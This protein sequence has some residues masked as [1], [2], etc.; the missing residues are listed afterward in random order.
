VSL[1]FGLFAGWSP[2]VALVLAG[3]L[4]RTTVERIYQA[5]KVR[6]DRWYFDDLPVG[7]GEWLE[8]QARDRGLSLRVFAAGSND[9]DIDAYYPSAR[10]ILLSQEVYYKCD[11]SFWAVAA[12][13]LGH[14]IVHAR[15]VVVHGAL[16]GAR[17]LS[18][19]FTEIGT[20]L[21]FANVLYAVHEIDAVAFA[22]LTASA[23][24]FVLVL[25]DEAAASIIAIRILARDRRVR[26]RGLLFACIRLLAA[27][28]TYVGALGGQVLLI[29]ERGF[30]MDKIEQ[31]RHFVPAPPL[32]SGGLLVTGLLSVFVLFFSARAILRSLRWTKVATG[33]EVTRRYWREALEVGAR[34]LLALPLLWLVWDQPFGTWFAVAC[35]LGL[36]ASRLV[37][38]VLVVLATGLLGFAVSILF[39]LALVPLL[40]IA[41]W[42]MVR[43]GGSGRSFSASITE[44]APAS[45]DVKRSEAAMEEM[46]LESYNERSWLGRAPVAAFAAG[47]IVFVVVLWA[48]LLGH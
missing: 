9:K 22:L 36:L 1:L 2:F 39:A 29:F 23:W 48:K 42:L 6:L 7:G 4:L 35:V 25:V 24:L 8:D 28:M 46:R 45:A 17:I 33:A 30:V 27:F 31:S 3:W 44:R 18:R 5:V 11:P 41:V 10:T 12:H 21:I 32:G 34:G 43:L 37:V 15:G 14:A 16:L 47:H 40:R 38:R 20:F 26:R 13:E 19:S